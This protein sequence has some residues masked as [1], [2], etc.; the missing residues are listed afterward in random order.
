MLTRTEI[1]FTPEGVDTGLTRLQFVPGL[2]CA[3][4]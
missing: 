3:K 2:Q 1:K 4:R